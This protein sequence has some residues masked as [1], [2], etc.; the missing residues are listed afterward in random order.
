MRVFLFFNF[1]KGS[2]ALSYS[3]NTLDFVNRFEHNFF[4]SRRKI[5]KRRLLEPEFNY[6][7]VY[8]IFVVLALLQVCIFLSFSNSMRE[9]H[10]LA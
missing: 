2:C 7:S 1:S 4:E 3:R 8:I 6:L 5:T 9:F 10:A